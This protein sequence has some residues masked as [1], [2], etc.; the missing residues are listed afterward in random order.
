MLT[1]KLVHAIAQ[2]L[3]QQYQQEKQT[4]ISIGY[5]ARLNSPAYAE[6]MRQVSCP[7]ISSDDGGLLFCSPML[8]FMARHT[9]GNG[10]MLTASHNPKI[11]QRH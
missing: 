9:A 10:I 3:V 6:I 4:Q 2:G 11:R 8:Y 7:S 1:A 5:D